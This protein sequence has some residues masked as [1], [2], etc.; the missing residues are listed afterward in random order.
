[1]LDANV[2]R[3]KNDSDHIEPEGISGLLETRDPDLSRSAELALLAPVHGAHRTSKVGRP[4]GLHFYESNCAPGIR[5]DAS[6][7]QVQISATIPKASLNNL[8]SVD[9]EPFL[10]HALAPD[11][12]RLLRHRHASEN[13]AKLRIRHT[14]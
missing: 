7:N 14:T 6:R 13:T 8:P 1:M 3:S 5:F 2:L 10:G 9:A 4:T 11:A 12:H